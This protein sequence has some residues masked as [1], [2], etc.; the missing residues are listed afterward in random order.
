MEPILVRLWLNERQRVR[1]LDRRMKP[2]MATLPKP[3]LKRRKAPSRQ[4][5]QRDQRQMSLF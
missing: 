3:R 1:R 5:K 2:I 4:K